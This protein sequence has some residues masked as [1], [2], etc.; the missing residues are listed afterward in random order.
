MELN[1]LKKVAILCLDFGKIER[2]TFHQDGITHETDT[3]HTVMLSVLAPALAEKLYPNLN[4]GLI[5]QFAIVHDLTEAITGDYDT[6]LNSSQEFKR[7]KKEQEELALKKIQKD[8][9]DNLP[10]IYKTIAHYERLDCPEAR[11]V[12]ILDK[13]LPKIVRL[14]G[15]RVSNKEHFQTIS[16]TYAKQIIDMEKIGHDMPELIQV[17]KIAQEAT[18]KEFYS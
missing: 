1:E 6:L 16:E 9:G 17:L 3:T 8:F 18:I 12:K 7:Q 13:I 5:A 15:N 4:I 2:K 11:F 10:W 14:V